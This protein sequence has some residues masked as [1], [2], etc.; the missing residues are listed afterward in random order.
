MQDRF[1]GKGPEVEQLSATM[2]DA[3][4]SFARTGD[5]STPRLTWQPYELEHRTTMVFDLCTSLEDAPLDDE[6][7]V[8]DGVI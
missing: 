3:W 6:R 5:P 2:M 4:L 7:A 1:A 8:W